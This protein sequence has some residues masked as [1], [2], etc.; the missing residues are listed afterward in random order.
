M[1]VLITGGAGFIGSH[2]VDFLLNDKRCSQVTKVI[3]LDALTYAGNLANLE[4]ARNDTRF[5]FVLGDICDEDVLRNL[6]PG[7]DVLVNFA[8]ESHVDNSINSSIPFVKTNVLGV[9]MLLDVIR[10]YSHI[11]FVQVSTDEVYGSISEGSWEEDFPLTPNSPYAASKASADLLCLAEF[12]TYGTNVLIT[13]CS[14]NYG[15][16]QHPEKLIPHFISKMILGKKVPLYGDGMNVREWIHVRDHCEGIWAAINRGN[17]GQI[18][19]IG[20][21]EERTNL[22]ITLALLEEFNL[23]I[24]CIDY[25]EDR[26][27]HDRRYSINF[28]KASIELGYKPQISFESG[29]VST[30][31]W[32]SQNFETWVRP[33]LPSTEK[34]SAASLSRKSEL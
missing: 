11:R 27:G 24:E 29:I 20:S 14:N 2:F 9:A 26:L 6:I 5:E 30:V 17:S 7:V 23:T 21:G 18:Y 33:L 4:T 16:N 15:P 25:V 3:V 8:A 28:Q 32:Y 13:R 22:E 12:N 1:R 10:N 19:N 31:E 34:A